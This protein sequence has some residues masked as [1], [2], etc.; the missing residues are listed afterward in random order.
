MRPFWINNKHAALHKL[1]YEASC[2]TK[3]QEVAGGVDALNNYR[4]PQAEITIHQ[5]VSRIGD[6][7]NAMSSLSS[8]IKTRSQDGNGQGAAIVEHG[9]RANSGLRKPWSQSTE[10]ADDAPHCRMCYQSRT[11]R[12][13][14]PSL[15]PK[16]AAK[17]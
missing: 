7:V 11:K 5:V 17:S 15:Q 10:S 16:F 2:L 12:Q 14:I 13:N 6:D 4:A 1:S 3:L 9:R 8:G